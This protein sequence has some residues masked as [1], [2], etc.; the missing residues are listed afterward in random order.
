VNRWETGS[1]ELHKVHSQQACVLQGGLDVRVKFFSTSE[2]SSVEDSL[3]ES[4]CQ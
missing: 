2:P 1:N 4:E 3:E